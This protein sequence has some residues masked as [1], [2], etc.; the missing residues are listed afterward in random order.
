MVPLKP[1]QPDASTD[2]TDGLDIRHKDCS[3]TRLPTLSKLALLSPSLF[4]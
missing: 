3:R 2:E 1:Q 4:G